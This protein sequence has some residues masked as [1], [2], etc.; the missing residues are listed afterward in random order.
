MRHSQLTLI[1]L[2]LC[3]NLTS[4]T[5]FST[6]DIEIKRIQSSAFTELICSDSTSL[7]NFQ[8]KH[9]VTIMSDNN[10]V[11]VDSQ[12][13]MITPLKIDGYANILNINIDDQRKLLELYSKYEVDYFKTELNVQTSDPIRQWV[14]TNSK[15]G[16]LIWFYRIT[17][18][19]DHSIKQVELQLYA[20]TIIGDKV[21]TINA[22]IF[23][24]TDFKK[25]S[26]IVN[27]F[28]ES[29]K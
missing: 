3:K 1:V 21:L 4:Q 10:L 2:L 25:A 18:T 16:W 15:T 13:I 12:L 28:M 23:S 19:P 24:I 17:N 26:Y 7:M 20:S 9:S 22:P 6:L 5:T 8:L 27:D 14:I 11:K 29:R